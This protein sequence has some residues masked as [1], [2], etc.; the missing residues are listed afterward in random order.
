MYWSTGLKQ[1]PQWSCRSSI[2]QPLATDWNTHALWATKAHWIIS[3]DAISPSADQVGTEVKDAK[4][5]DVAAYVRG[6]WLVTH[7]PD[8]SWLWLDGEN[9]PVPGFR[10]I[11]HR[12][13]M[14]VK[15]VHDKQT[16][17]WS[18]DE[19]TIGTVALPGEMLEGF[20]QLGFCDNMCGTLDT[21]KDYLNTQQD[22]LS[23]D[24]SAPPDT[25]CNALSYAN[26]FK[27]AQILA[28]MNDVRPTKPF[29]TCPQPRHPAAPRQ[30]CTC[31]SDGS[32]CTFEGGL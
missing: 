1:L 6:G 14:T 18:M 22:S 13:V 19:G 15:L 27:A 20:A 3:Q 32:K 26:V 28:D 31:S 7:F 10:E 29:T 4:A 25:K 5:E 24:T 9:T 23:T 16:D 12:S 11:M 30:G 17:L 8:G 2:D 21:V